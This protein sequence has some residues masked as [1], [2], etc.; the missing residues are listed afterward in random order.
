MNDL[1]NCN[2][3]FKHDAFFIL[4]GE[5]VMMPLVHIPRVGCINQTILSTIWPQITK[6]CTHLLS[7]EVLIVF[8]LPIVINTR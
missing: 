3:L 2:I 6:F 4:C 8:T 1:Y 5:L 7:T